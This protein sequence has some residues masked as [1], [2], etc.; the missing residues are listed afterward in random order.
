MH[1]RAVNQKKL[2][3]CSSPTLNT[4]VCAY[5]C[6]GW[7]EMSFASGGIFIEWMI[8]ASHGSGIWFFFEIIH[9]RVTK[10]FLQILVVTVVCQIESD[11]T[12]KLEAQV[13]AKSTTEAMIPIVEFHG[14]IIIL[15]SGQYKSTRC[16]RHSMWPKYFGSWFNH[17]LTMGWPCCGLQAMLPETGDLESI[18]QLLMESALSK[19]LFS[20]ASAEVW[21]PCYRENCENSH[22]NLFWYSLIYFNCFAKPSEKNRRYTRRVCV[23]VCVCHLGKRLGFIEV[24]EPWMLPASLGPVASVLNSERRMPSVSSDVVGESR[25]WC[26]GGR[27]HLRIC[28]AVLLNSTSICGSLCCK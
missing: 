25:R 10:L 24:L 18:S 27:L 1:S 6:H 4:S 8:C 19:L 20:S 16:T 12:L 17:G 28:L 23:C 5:S 13:S 9:P 2:A 7:K 21:S 15:D 11:S 22:F 14:L 3:D 26:D